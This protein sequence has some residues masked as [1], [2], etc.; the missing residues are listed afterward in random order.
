MHRTSGP[1]LLRRYLVAPSAMAEWR[2]LG[3]GPSY[4]GLA[5]V[6][7]ASVANASE[8]EAPG[9]DVARIQRTTRQ[10]GESPRTNDHPQ[11]RSIA[12]L[13]ELAIGFPFINPLFE[14]CGTGVMNDIVGHLGAHAPDAPS[15]FAY[16][17]AFSTW[18][19]PMSTRLGRLG[20]R[21]RR[22]LR[23]LRVSMAP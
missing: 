19:Q 16:D 18:E 3:R 9:R 12:T 8:P 1:R 2:R 17:R 14:L 4:S 6:I 5:G 15:L 22:S 20:R 23:G 7:G 11:P 21:S 10:V 13:F